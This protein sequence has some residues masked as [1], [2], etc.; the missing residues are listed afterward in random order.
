ME[1]IGEDCGADVGFARSRRNTE[2]LMRGLNA[3]PVSWSRL[4]AGQYLF[5]AVCDPRRDLSLFPGLDVALHY[6]ER[7]RS[8]QLMP[9][10]QDI[11]PVEMQDF[12]PRVALLDVMRG[13]V[14][15]RYRVSGTGVCQVHHRDVTGLWADALEPEPYGGM[16]H[17]QYAG[18][19]RTRQPAMHLNVFSSLD[20][21]RAYTHLL[22]PLGRDH[23][24]VD[25][26]LSVDSI[27][28]DKAEMME[29]LAHL[30]QRAEIEPSTA[31]PWRTA[32]H[33]LAVSGE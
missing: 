32:R 27:A 13:P 17:E 20:R 5:T 6:W 22:L 31:R 33:R 21:Y 11:D 4:N 14:R 30:Q 16:M 26:I 24:D 23:E 1:E 18:V 12:I 8:E 2:R 3:V 29:V 19:L 15:F 28:Q 25:M 9:G 10:R 7:K